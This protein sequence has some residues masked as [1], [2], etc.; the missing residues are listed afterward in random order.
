MSTFLL[1]VDEIIFRRYLDQTFVHVAAR[2]GFGTTVNDIWAHFSPERMLKLIS[3][4]RKRPSAL[5]YA[6]LAE[7]A[8][9]NTEDLLFRFE[10]Q[11]A[12]LKQS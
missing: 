5:H 1:E 7:N 8:E 3:G 12:Q 4:E 10:Y 11:D 2:Y 9:K 6:M